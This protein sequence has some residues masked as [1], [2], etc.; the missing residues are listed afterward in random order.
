MTIVKIYT[1]TDAKSAKRQDARVI[2]TLET[3]TSKGPA[4]RTWIEEVEA[5]ANEAALIAII[6]AIQHITMPCDLEIYTESRFVASAFGWLP[7]WKENDWKTA[8]GKEVA[9][10]EQ[11][12]QLDNLITGRNITIHCQEDN[13]FRKWQK[14]ELKRWKNEKMHNMRRNVRTAN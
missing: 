8:K 1:M 13:S 3:Q 2:F 12:Q 4:D 6:M 9:H 5:T 7:G 11:W 10:K 14:F